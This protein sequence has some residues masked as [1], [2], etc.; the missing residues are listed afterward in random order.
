MSKKKN[1]TIQTIVMVGNV[2]SLPFIY[3]VK[4]FF[5]TGLYCS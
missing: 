3:L 2:N 1:T 4:R 5:T